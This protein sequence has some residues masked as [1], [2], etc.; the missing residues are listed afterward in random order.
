[1]D[2][3][4][5]V[6][7]IGGIKGQ[8]MDMSSFNG[9]NVLSNE[10]NYWKNFIS[11]TISTYIRTPELPPA[12]SVFLPVPMAASIRFNNRQQTPKAFGDNAMPRE[13]YRVHGSRE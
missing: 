13:F 5:T 10:Q 4:A 11:D 8:P 2:G 3:L 9:G 12:E 1:V 7:T 6:V